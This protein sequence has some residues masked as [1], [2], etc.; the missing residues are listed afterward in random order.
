MMKKILFLAM[1]LLMSSFLFSQTSIQEKSDQLE[2][3]GEYQKA[4][5]LLSKSFK[6]DSPDISLSW[7]IASITFE[8]SNIANEKKEKIQWFEEGEKFTKPYMF[9]SIGTNIDQAELIHWYCVNYASRMKLLG[10]FGG[11][12]AMGVVPVIFD[13]MDKCLEI[14]PDYAAAYFFKAKLFEDVPFFLGGDK[15]LMGFHY[16][17]AVERSADKIKF[18]IYLDAAKGFLKRNW[19][20]E[21]KQKESQKYDQY[22]NDGTP[23]NKTD[24]EYA[25]SILRKAQNLYT[26]APAPSAREKRVYPE[27]LELLTKAQE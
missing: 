22:K 24:K 5:E 14:N 26:S 11:R 1:I 6:P 8:L 23:D 7:R 16:V 25:L 20:I 2:R 13:L 18:L 9:K 15:F 21:K 12:E 17:Q 4:F 3:D 10:I 27:L 19:S